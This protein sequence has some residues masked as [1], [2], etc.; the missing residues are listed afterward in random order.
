MKYNKKI[1]TTIAIA[2]MTI[3]FCYLP[4]INMFTITDIKTGKLVYSRSI[5]HTQNFYTSFI[6]S[7]NRVP[8]YEYYKIVDNKFVIYKTSFYSYGAGMPEYNPEHHVTIANGIIT[9]DNLNIILDKFAIFVGTVA[10]HKVIFEDNE[11]NLSQF[12][13]PGNDLKFEVK[14]VPIYYLIKVVGL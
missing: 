13:M 8:V 3:G 10:N 5:K 6:H 11:Y 14:R 4:A 2:F 12:T 9:I 1:I 7:V